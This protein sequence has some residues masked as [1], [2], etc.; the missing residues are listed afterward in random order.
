MESV[1][2]TWRSGVLT[3]LLHV[4]CTRSSYLSLRATPELATPLAS[5]AAVVCR[6]LLIAVMGPSIRAVN[7]LIARGGHFVTRSLINQLNKQ[8]KLQGTCDQCGG[9]H[10]NKGCK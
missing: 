9:T 4:L 2:L 7:V 1:S 8:L 3:R 10:C 6:T 5:F